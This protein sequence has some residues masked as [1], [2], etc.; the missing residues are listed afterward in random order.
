MSTRSVIAIEDLDKQCRGI[1]CHFDGY[2][3]NN[4]RLLVEHYNTPEL[5]EALLAL[6]NLSCLGE[7]L[8]PEPGEAHDYD[9]PVRD[10]CI[11][12]H[13]DRGED[14]QPPKFWH[15]ANYLLSK[16]SDSY[17]A[18]YVYLF[19]EGLWYVDSAYQPLGWRPVAEV[20]KDEESKSDE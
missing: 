5:A 19:R 12:Y 8:A 10:I 17:W 3:S 16:A 6:G 13:R 15:D 20:L 7:R 9:N 1:Y 4:G 2:V 18:E 11:A 14:Y